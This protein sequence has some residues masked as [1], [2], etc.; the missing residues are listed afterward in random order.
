M[1][2]KR[3]FG[4]LIFL[5][6]LASVAFLVPNQDTVQASA[7]DTSDAVQVVQLFEVNSFLQS[8]TAPPACT[9]FNLKPCFPPPHTVE[10][11]SPWGAS[12]CFCVEAVADSTMFEWRCLDPEL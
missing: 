9:D 5:G 3:L 1:L 7:L 12:R 8:S 4:V 2:K 10:C 6:L 11:T